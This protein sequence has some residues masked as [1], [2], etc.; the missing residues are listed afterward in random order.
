[1]V[2]LKNLLN[3]EKNRNRHERRKAEKI[4]R[5]QRKSEQKAKLNEKAKEGLLNTFLL[6]K[7]FDDTINMLENKGE[8]NETETDS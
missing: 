2:H 7:E 5:V 6:A 4:S 1:L 8:V 3:K